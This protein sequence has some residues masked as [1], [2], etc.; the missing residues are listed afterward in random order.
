MN[1]FIRWCGRDRLASSLTPLDIEDY[2]ASLEGTGEEGNRRLGITKGFLSYLHRVSLTSGNLA[3][4]AKLRRGGRAIAPSKRARK[5]EAPVHLT[6]EAYQQ[7]EAELASLKADRPMVAKE[8][9]RAAAD[10]DVSENAPLD[11]AREKQGY[12]EARIRELENMLHRVVI[13]A[14]GEFGGPGSKAGLGANVVLRQVDSGREVTYLLVETNEADP[15][16]G[17]LSVASPV[18][19]AILNHVVGDSVDVATPGG[20]VSYLVAKIR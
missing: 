18:G 14:K 1:R 10:K 8:I 4:H 7:L 13:L 12:M 11:A 2:C 16:N 19:K 9:R 6:K 15:A 17:K 5:A 20:T 3:P